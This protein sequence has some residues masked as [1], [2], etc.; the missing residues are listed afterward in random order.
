M[1][2]RYNGCCILM[3][4]V[5]RELSNLRTHEFHFTESQS[6]S[7]TCTGIGCTGELTDR[8]RSRGIKA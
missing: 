2:Y 8:G 3:K 4:K 1:S 5:F 7:G 6:D